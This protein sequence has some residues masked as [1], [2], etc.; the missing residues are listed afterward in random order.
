MAN[1]QISHVHFKGYLSMLL[2]FCV[3]PFKNKRTTHIETISA[4]K[5][6]R[7]EI[8]SILHF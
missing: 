3:V 8:N 6:Q 1:N 4:E 7:W 2:H 5:S